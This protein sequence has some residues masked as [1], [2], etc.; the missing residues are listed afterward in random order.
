MGVIAIATSV[1]YF[2]GE[3]KYSCESKK[4]PMD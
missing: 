1:D 3:K 4:F 2:G